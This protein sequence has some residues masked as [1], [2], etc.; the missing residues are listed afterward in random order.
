MVYTC[1]TSDAFKTK[2]NILFAKEASVSKH[3]GSI[4]VIDTD[5]LGTTNELL[6]RRVKPED[7][8]II[9]RSKTQVCNIRNLNK[10][11]KPHA[12][13]FNSFAGSWHKEVRAAYIDSCSAF[14]T[15]SRGLRTMFTRQ[16]FTDNCVLFITCVFR[17]DSSTY[18]LPEYNQW[19]RDGMVAYPDDTACMRKAN[20]QLY[21][22]AWENGYVLARYTKQ[23]VPVSQYRRGTYLLRYVIKY[24]R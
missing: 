4:V 20:L 1:N 6:R 17:N 15:L 2:H 13:E 18:N 11:L 22:M 9:N 10:K 5:E 23:Q 19:L 12:V 7:I 8:R 16:V 21:K 3:S 14:D 24:N